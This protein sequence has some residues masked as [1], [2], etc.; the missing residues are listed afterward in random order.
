M[1]TREFLCLATAA[2]S[3]IWS[4]FHGPIANL[5]GASDPFSADLRGAAWP[6]A[7]PATCPFPASG[8]ITAVCF[9]GRR[10]EYENA[11][12]WYPSW[13]SDDNLYSPFTDGVVGNVKSYSA[14]SWETPQGTL[15]DIFRGRFRPIRQPV[16]PG[17]QE[18][19]R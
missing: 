12:T 7:C 13:A 2:T 4:P 15:I 3:P 18:P 6:S 19:T 11:D 8:E 5:M 10:R 16:K 1:K 14:G 17:S 9:T